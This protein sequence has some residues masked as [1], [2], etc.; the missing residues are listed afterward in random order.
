M[1]RILIAWAVTLVAFA[2]C[3]NKSATSAKIEGLDF[4]SIVVDTTAALT[5]LKLTPL[6]RIS[7]NLQYAKGNNADKINN[8]LLHAGILM[9]DYLGLTNQKFSMEQAV[10]SFV[11]RMLNDYT[12]DYAA[13]YRQDRENG[14]SYN[15]EYKVKTSTRNGV[16]NIVVYTA[17][18]YT[19]GGG[20]HGINQTLVRNIDVTTGKVLQLQDVFVPGYEPTLKELLLK[21]VGER[22]NADGLDELNKKDIFADGHVYVPDNFAIDDDGFTFIY[23]EDEIAPHAVGEISVTLSRSELSR[24]LK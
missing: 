18:I 3:T 7:L 24:I 15:Y 22:F 13:L 6:C 9:P 21:K 8:A 11:K 14:S 20:A 12:T 5:D 23:C 1:K 2:A 10:D 19:Y 16:E 17:K 4:D